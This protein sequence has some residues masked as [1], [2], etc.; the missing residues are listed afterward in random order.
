M[1]AD[2]YRSFSA[3]GAR[4][5]KGTAFGTGSRA[6][7]HATVRTKRH[8]QQGGPRA[9]VRV[10]TSPPWPLDTQKASGL[11]WFACV[12]DFYDAWVPSLG[13]ISIV[14]TAER[15][16][17]HCALAIDHKVLYTPMEA[18]AS[19][20]TAKSQAEMLSFVKWIC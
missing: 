9:R 14:R 20:G 6:V 1:V 8:T 18:V 15:S 2:I 17:V 7:G 19:T 16:R 3:A 13:W 12:I 11:F 10:A 4:R 5:D